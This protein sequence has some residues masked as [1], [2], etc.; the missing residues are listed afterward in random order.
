[1]TGA[2]G[3]PPGAQPAPS[4]VERYSKAIASLAGVL[5]P[6]AVV[7]VLSLVGVH[8]GSVWAAA[9]V[10]VVSTLATVLAP[11]NA[12]KPAPDPGGTVEVGG[13]VS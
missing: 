5:T 4:F 2:H 8:I 7:G 1:M 3:Y 11:A 10:A 6:S 12:A 13:A 9:V